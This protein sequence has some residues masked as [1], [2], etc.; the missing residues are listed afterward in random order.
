M[1][2]GL[3]EA[4]CHGAEEQ[5]SI[6]SSPGAGGLVSALPATLRRGGHCLSSRAFVLSGSAS[7]DTIPIGRCRGRGSRM[8]SFGDFLSL[9]VEEPAEPAPMTHRDAAVHMSSAPRPV[10]RHSHEG[11]VAEVGMPPEIREADAEIVEY[12]AVEGADGKVHHG[13]KVH[14]FHHGSPLKEVPEPVGNHG[15]V[16]GE[17]QAA[18]QA[19]HAREAAAPQEA[20]VSQEQE[21]P[22]PSAGRSEAPVAPALAGDIREGQQPSLTV[23]VLLGG[24]IATLIQVYLWATVFVT[25]FKAPPRTPSPAP[26]LEVAA[27]ASASMPVQVAPPVGRLAVAAFDEDRPSST[28]SLPIVGSSGSQPEDH[29]GERANE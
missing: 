12:W 7:W 17:G 4:V 8:S 5:C 23:S 20:Q 16:R 10:R 11:V 18:A 28:P 27:P 6:A 25:L 24:A 29:S 22:G 15:D 1:P 14:R 2:R 13:H 26:S 19:Q 9:H 21:E 3:L